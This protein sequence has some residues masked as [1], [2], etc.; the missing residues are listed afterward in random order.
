MHR[1]VRVPTPEECAAVWLPIEIYPEDKD[2]I[3]ARN[4]IGLK[5]LMT[6]QELAPWTR[7]YATFEGAKIA[8]SSMFGV[9]FEIRHHKQS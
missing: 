7:Y 3:L 1:L 2:Y 8:V 4:T 5:W 9:W 6:P